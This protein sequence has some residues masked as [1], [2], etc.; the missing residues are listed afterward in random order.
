MPPQGR[1]EW[2]HAEQKRQVST[3]KDFPD[4]LSRMLRIPAVIATVFLGG[5]CHLFRYRWV[6]CGPC[7]IAGRSASPNSR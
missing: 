7:F 3:F 4:L 5:S 6:G 2:S 1:P